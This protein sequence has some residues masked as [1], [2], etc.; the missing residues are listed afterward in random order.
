MSLIPRLA[1][2]CNLFFRHTGKNQFKGLLARDVKAELIL[3]LGT[4]ESGGDREG[5]G[6]KGLPSRD[7][8]VSLPRDRDLGGW[9]RT[10]FKVGT[11]ILVEWEH[12]RPSSNAT[13]E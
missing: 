5:T 11:A 3:V 10:L 2:F 4:L 1:V 6:L 7:P 13:W 8:E 12:R 9:K